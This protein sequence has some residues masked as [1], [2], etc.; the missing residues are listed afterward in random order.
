MRKFLLLTF[1]GFIC[2]NSQAQEKVFLSDIFI[3]ALKSGEEVYK[4][5]DV[6]ISMED[7]PTEE[8]DTWR[9]KE[10][11]P[12]PFGDYLLQLVDT[13]STDSLGRPI[14][15]VRIE[16]EDVRGGDFKLDRLSL[17]KGVLLSGNFRDVN[18]DYCN[19][20]H[21]DFDII[22]RNI[23]VSI[24]S[25]HGG[26]WNLESSSE[27]YR[28]TMI[29]ANTVHDLWNIKV[30]NSWGFQ[31]YGNR[32]KEFK[33]DG[34]SNLDTANHLINRESLTYREILKIACESVNQMW[35]W[36]NFN[37]ERDTLE[38]S[39]VNSLEGYYRSSPDDPVFDFEGQYNAMVNPN[40]NNIQKIVISGDINT[41]NIR[42]NVFANTLV[43]S[44][45][46][47][48]ENLTIIE[49]RFNTPKALGL[50]EAIFPELFVNINW[51]QFEG[52]KIFLVDDLLRFESSAGFH[53][54]GGLHYFGRSY[55]EMQYPDRLRSLLS[56]YNMFYKT[57]RERG[58][59]DAANSVYREIQSI[60]TMKY[61][62]E[63]KNGGTLRDFFKWRLN[64]LLEWYTDYG[65]SPA[66]ALVISFY[67][68][69]AFA[70]FY[71]FF[72]SEW[73][74][75]SKT[76]LLENLKSAY[77]KHESGTGKALLSAVGL[78]L[79]SLVNAVTLSLNSFVT[80][81]FG[82]IPTS[83]L[84]RYVCILQGFIGWFLLSI[85]SV[86]LINQVLF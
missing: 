7:I 69:L 51:R 62:Y 85:F 38:S 50:R 20:G 72:P 19:L 65:T 36:E 35:F 82:T 8:V 71:F 70:A 73:D 23:N 27:A 16:L 54:Q 64:Q 55:D 21:S 22:S 78:F 31:F 57:Y 76:K 66:K 60:M 77:N 3:D 24:N 80:L 6:E 75:M 32:I 58:E 1:L 45:L 74:V 47:V 30:R 79:L 59:I 61:E 44:G 39:Y 33:S 25:L 43:L 15:S 42:K 40:F 68:I 52:H 9:G 34:M 26:N 14:V 49:N 46:V 29:N 28:R 63:A 12:I 5:S 41:L 4:V 13:L 81:G 84:A 53:M 67:I 2:F 83:G 37:T 10:Q 17:P 18:I 86:A 48:N 11:Q 56:Y